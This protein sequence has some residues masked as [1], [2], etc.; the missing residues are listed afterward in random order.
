[1]KSDAYPLDPSP[2]GLPVSDLRPPEFGPSFRDLAIAIFREAEANGDPEWD[3]ATPEERA[4]AVAGRILHAARVPD[5]IAQAGFTGPGALGRYE[6]AM[7]ALTR[8]TVPS[9]GRNG[10]LFYTP[11]D[12]AAMTTPATD[13]IVGPGLLAIGAITEVDGK[14]K[15][16]GKTTFSLHMVRAILDGADFLGYP[17]RKARVLY[18]TE[19]SRHT[20]VDTLRLCGLDARGSE[21]R[22]L[23]REDL[24]GT[25]W[26]SVV[27]ACQQDG[28]DVAVF[29]TL[30]KLARI[31][32]ENEAGEWAT[33]MSPLQDL[34]ASGRAVLVDRHDRKG[35]GDVG[36][37]GRGSSQAS[38][39][40]DIILAL[41]RPEG[42]QPSCRRVIESLSRY[43]ET[44]EKIVIELTPDG[45]V[46]L[47]TKEAVATADAETFVSCALGAEF[48][49]NR[50]GLARTVL[51]ERGGSA[52]PKVAEWAIRAALA[53]LEA[54]G[55]VAKTGRGVKGDPYIYS[56]STG[57]IADSC[58]TQTYTHETN[59]DPI[60][61]LALDVW[62]DEIVGSTP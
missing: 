1:M 51:E 15:A 30:G 32:Q 18:V 58:E 41:R 53:S 34:A 20:F 17:T 21:L 31:K 40:V 23:F 46:F 19:Q 45:Y 11:L 37:S 50:I 6:A 48:R 44:P 5:Q 52:I 57:G 25:P 59:T 3:H 61:A 62:G 35:G 4:A 60:L 33:A 16:A 56:P 12:L 9:E 54:A 7:A 24:S 22:I 28:Y 38:G 10:L 49:T 13:W 47:G 36:D 55:K 27:A 42:D 2:R 29:D 8:P 14:I 43:R 26:P 39:D